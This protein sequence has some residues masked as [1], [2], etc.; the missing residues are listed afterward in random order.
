MK[1]KGEMK[2]ANEGGGGDS[3]PGCVVVRQG[4]APISWTTFTTRI[5]KARD[6]RFSDFFAL[7]DFLCKNRGKD[8]KD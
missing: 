1:Q 4:C 7:E 3:R 8:V 5:E 2:L 6:K